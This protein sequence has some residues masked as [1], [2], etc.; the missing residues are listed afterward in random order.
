MDNINSPSPDNPPV[1]ASNNAAELFPNYR[2]SIKCLRCS[3]L[4]TITFDSKLFPFYKRYKCSQCQHQHYDYYIRNQ[5]LRQHHAN[6]LPQ[7]QHQVSSPPPSPVDAPSSLT[8]SSPSPCIMVTDPLYDATLQA[9]QQ[10]ALPN[11]VHSILTELATMTKTLNQLKTQ[12]SER[13]LVIQQLQQSLSCLTRPATP[14]TTPPQQPTVPHISTRPAPWSD[15]DQV[16]RLRHNLSPSP[17]SRAQQKNQ[18]AARTFFPVS[19]TRG[20]TYIYLHTNKRFPTKELRSKYRSLGINTSRILD[21]HYPTRNVIAN[22]IHNDYQQDF[23]ARLSS[24]GIDPLDH[25]D[26]LDPKHIHDP[27][28]TGDDL[29]NEEKTSYAAQIVSVR[30]AHTLSYIKPPSAL[31]LA[32]TSSMKDGSTKK[33]VMTP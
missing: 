12:I 26:P 13:D 2:S 29:S 21:I 28:Y 6:R 3:K 7:Q 16:Q 17:T 25:F 20:F 11:Y 15:N 24:F 22:L 32:T 18:A 8:N 1:S 9:E 27:R 33:L 31:Q 23:L 30:M 10:P 14:P 5:V 4:A 19:P